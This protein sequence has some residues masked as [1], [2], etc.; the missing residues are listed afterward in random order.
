MEPAALRINI[1]KTSDKTV[2]PKGEASIPRT[3]VSILE[4]VTYGKAWRIASTVTAT[5]LV[6]A[7]AGGA[8]YGA[9]ISGSGQNFHAYYLLGAGAA[10]GICAGAYYLGKHGDRRITTI[11][12]VPEP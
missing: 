12:I 10:V 11:R 3:D 7:I 4:L 6:A 9:A 2:Q 1:R 8:A 5:G